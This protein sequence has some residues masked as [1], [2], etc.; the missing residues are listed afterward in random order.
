[1]GAVLLDREDRYP[2]LPGR[3]RNLRAVPAAL[4]FG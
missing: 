2:D 1:M 3:I 4:G